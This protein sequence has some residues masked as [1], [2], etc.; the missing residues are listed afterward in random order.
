MK[1]QSSRRK[2]IQSAAL[3]VAAMSTGV[4]TSAGNTSKFQDKK[5]MPP[6]KLGLI[7]YTLGKEWEN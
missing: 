7:T 2:F 1:L 3:G 4:H 5:K 6:L